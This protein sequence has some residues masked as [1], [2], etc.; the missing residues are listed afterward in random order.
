MNKNIIIGLGVAAAAVAGLTALFFNTQLIDNTLPAEQKDRNTGTGISVGETVQKDGYTIERLPDSPGET[1]AQPHLDRP[2]AKPEAMDDAVF[3]QIKSNIA[4][5]IVVLKDGDD[6]NAWMNLSTLRTIL[7]DYQGSE[8]ILVY[9]ARRYA[10]SWQVH[11]NLGALYSTYLDNLDG[12]IIN[13]QQAIALLP[14]NPALYRSLYETYIRKGAPNEA[15]AAL[16]DGIANEPR[17]IDLYVL[18]ARY[19][20]DTGDVENARTYYAQAISQAEQAGNTS[21]KT[22]LEAELARLP[23]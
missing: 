18:L 2:L 10:P 15:I 22:E 19:Y 11:A 6:F 9:L 7:E 16:K 21:A 14:S 5:T 17:A 3:A 23:Q 8:E 1:I 20:R 12:A 13:Y 4:E